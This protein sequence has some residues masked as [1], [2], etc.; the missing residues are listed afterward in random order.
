MSAPFGPLM[1][2]PLAVALG[3]ALLAGQGRTTV[4]STTQSPA[5]QA[6]PTPPA[7]APAQPAAQPAAQPPAPQK[8]RDW[9]A[10]LAA[11]APSRPM[12]YFLLA[13]EVADQAV[14]S[15]DRALARQ[16]FG[17]AGALAPKELG[18]SA[19]LALASLAEDERERRT[20]RA[21]ASLLAPD[22]APIGGDEISRG[23][24]SPQHALALSE[25]F[26][27][28]RRGQG[29]RALGILKTPEVALLLDAY[30][31]QLPGGSE[32]FREDCRVFKSGVRPSYAE[33]QKLLML[34][35]ERAVLG[36]A[37]S[38]PAA[39]GGGVAQ[40]EATVAGWSS[41]LV[42]TGGAPLLEL[43]TARLE[44]AY[45]VDP[46]R[47]VWRN[48]QWERPSDRPAPSGRG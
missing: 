20:L 38:G 13:E 30:A 43:D 44:N 5:G 34:E 31:S 47:S 16:L 28:L 24:P 45:G 15:D 40:G 26:S 35:I 33:G 37:G 7:T 1:R 10:R 8:P 27:Q 32:R 9:S 14:A 4:A 22:D 21:L 23:R 12:D 46:A 3:L 6:T 19:A 11:L 17:L 29:P 41:S 48:G 39:G 25:A 18:R 42:A 36:M 2:T